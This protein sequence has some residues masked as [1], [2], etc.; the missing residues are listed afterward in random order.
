M[1][2]CI[3]VDESYVVHYA[4]QCVHRFNSMLCM[5]NCTYIYDCTYNDNNLTPLV[6]DDALSPVVGSNL[7]YLCNHVQVP[8]KFEYVTYD[9]CVQFWT[10]EPIEN[11]TELGL[12]DCAHKFKRRC[13]KT[14]KSDAIRSLDPEIPSAACQ[15]DCKL[16]IPLPKAM[17]SKDQKFQS[18]EPSSSHVQPFLSNSITGNVLED[19]DLNVKPSDVELVV[20]VEAILTLDGH[21]GGI[22]RV[23]FIVYDSMFIMH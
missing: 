2:A 10:D 1:D 17:E 11:A 22:D 3:V 12:R 16:S 13:W 19:K 7:T 20:T 4:A 6:S 23:I 18:F 21:D 14:S 15:I 5:L 9:G 8:P